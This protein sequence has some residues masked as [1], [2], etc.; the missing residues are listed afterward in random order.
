MVRSLAVGLGARLVA[1]DRP[2]AGFEVILDEVRPGA[3]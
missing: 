2:G 1:Q 3:G